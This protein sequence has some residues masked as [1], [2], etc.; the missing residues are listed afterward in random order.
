MIPRTEKLNIVDEDGKIIGE[1][2]RDDIHNKGLLHREVHVWF[3]TPGGDVIFQRRSKDVDTYPDKLDATVGGHVGIGSNYL[4][5]ALKEMSEETGT[6]T[7]PE[8][9]VLTEIMRSTSLD[10]MTNKTNN[11]LRAIYLYRYEDQINK[12]K[13][14]SDTSQGFEAWP[15][16]KLF[17]LSDNE[18]KRFIP[19][20][21]SDRYMKVY[22]TIQD[23]VNRNNLIK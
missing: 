18:K 5:T 8:S 21:L 2:T 14:E 20:I 4:A 3:Y 22:K 15:V 23:I 6:Q 11:T 12:L 13:I 1:A 9:L 19:L 17:G 7:Q 16:E 10:V